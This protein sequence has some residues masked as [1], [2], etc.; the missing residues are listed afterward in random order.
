MK[1]PTIEEVN[2]ADIE[3]LVKWYRFLNSPGLNYVDSELGIF[4]YKI[5]EET[6]IINL[7]C[8]RI[9][10]VGGFTPEISKRIGWKK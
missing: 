3:Q 7:I 8:Q 2:N 5:K 10:E 4:K 6:S 9:N 1:Y